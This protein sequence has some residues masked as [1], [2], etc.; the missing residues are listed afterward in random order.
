MS[1]RGCGQ[2]G[3]KNAKQPQY[4]T[5]E[6][7]DRTVKH[8]IENGKSATSVAEEMRIDTRSFL[9]CIF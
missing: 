8:I 4:I 6:I 2:K 7:R 9:L 1:K 5:H 3:G